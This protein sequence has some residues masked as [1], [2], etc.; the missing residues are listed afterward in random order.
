MIFPYAS[1]RCGR[2]AGSLRALRTTLDEESGLKHGISKITANSRRRKP[3]KSFLM[4][5]LCFTLI[6][7]ASALP[8]S[9]GFLLLPRDAPPMTR[10]CPKKTCCT[11]LCYV[12]KHGVHHCVHMPGSD[13]CE[14][15]LSTH[16]LSVDPILFSAIATLPDFERP[17]P[18]PQAAGR[19]I[20]IRTSIASYDP[21]TPSPPPK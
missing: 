11:P 13:S 16:D 19:V 8:L 3:T 5:L 1:Q 17:I 15:G 14:R 10:G 6:S 4:L 20:Q 2:F 21:A 12:D 18:A 7:Q 9:I